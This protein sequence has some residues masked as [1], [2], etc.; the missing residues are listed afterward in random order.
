MSCTDPL[1]VPRIIL[2]NFKILLLEQ[3]A[4]STISNS[5]VF[6]MGD[7]NIDFLEPNNHRDIKTLLSQWGFYQTIKQATRTSDTTSTL[8]DLLFTNRPNNIS[9]T[10]VIPTTFSDHD[11]ICWVKKLSREKY[12][13]KEIKCTDNKKYSKELSC[14]KL[15]NADWQNVLTATNVNVSWNSMREIIRSCLDSIAG[16]SPN[17]L[18]ENH[19]HR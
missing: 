13:P 6:I 10:L 15:K 19:V 5:E 12:A 1:I 2:K 14:G 18:V 17:E 4:R 16:S 3:L 8:I 9:R 11:L 7:F